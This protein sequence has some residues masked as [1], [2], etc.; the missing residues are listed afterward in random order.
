MTA[1]VHALVD[2]LFRRR[3]GQMVAALTRILGPAHLDLAEDVVQEALVKALRVW[4]FQ[5]VPRNPGAWL[6][7][8]AKN[9]ALDRIRRHGWWRDHEPELRRWAERAAG[10]AADADEEIRDDQLRLMFMCCHAALPADAQVALTLKTLCGF[11][12][13]EIARAFLTQEPTIA[14]R[15]V[16]AKRRLQEERVAFDVPQGA[17]LRARLDAVL[18]VLYLL[19]NEGYTASAGE[20]LVRRDLADEAVRLARLLLDLP[21][22]RQPKVHALLALMLFQAARLPCRTDDAGELLLLAQQDRSRWDRAMI[23]EGFVHLHHAGRGDELTDYHLEAGIA[24]THA[25]A[26][27]FATTDW[28][29]ILT[30]YDLMLARKPSPVV[31]LNRAVAVS[32]VHGPEAALRDLE[33]WQDHPS[34]RSYF[35]LPATRGEL[36]RRLGRLD[37]AAECFRHALTL[38]ATEPERRFLR[39]KLAA[40]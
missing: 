28:R 35:L 7:Q 34:M 23:Q 30:L 19:F 9:R 1:G 2:H 32:M 15:L 6:I 16:R 39:K 14:Q 22:T 37:E 26:G 20:D 21:A 18:Q 13:S 4:P 8:T 3:A 29:H 31:A 27:T 12:V 40:V 38:T 25:L 33:A 36:L 10:P 5:G 17:D 24:S 11:G